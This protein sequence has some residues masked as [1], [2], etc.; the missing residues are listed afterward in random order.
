VVSP[1][2]NAAAS[3]RGS[4]VAA[5]AIRSTTSSVSFIVAAI[6]LCSDHQVIRSP[7]YSRLCPGFLGLRD[8]E[9]SKAFFSYWI[10]ITG[11]LTLML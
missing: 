4:T 9:A 7:L 5:A 10:Y 2:T 3:A 6:C 11:D 1:T 8:G